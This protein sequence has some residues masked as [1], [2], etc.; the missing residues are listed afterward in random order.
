M[1]VVVS[2]LNLSTCHSVCVLTKLS[3]LTLTSWKLHYTLKH[4]TTKSPIFN[5]LQNLRFLHVSLYIFY[6]F[7][8]ISSPPVDQFTFFCFLFDNGIN[9]SLYFQFDYIVTKFRSDI[10]QLKETLKFYRH[11]LCFP[12]IFQGVRLFDISSGYHNYL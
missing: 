7:L 4:Y 10:E 11:P 5:R 2:N 3:L 9:L 12:Y 8:P 6:V 1:R